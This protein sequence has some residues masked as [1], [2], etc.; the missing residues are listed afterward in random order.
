MSLY[1]RKTFYIRSSHNIQ[2]PCLTCLLVREPL[3]R[4][5]Q[6]DERGRLQQLEAHVDHGEQE[7]RP[8]H[9]GGVGQLQYGGA[10]L[11]V[12]TACFH[13][14]SPPLP[15]GCKVLDK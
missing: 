11:D 12:L 9:L 4:P 15:E 3:V 6:C 8:D 13:S 5:E 7:E 2:C 1:D 14:D 10:Q